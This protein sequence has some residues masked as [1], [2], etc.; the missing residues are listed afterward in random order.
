MI[1]C[2]FTNG[3]LVVLRQSKFVAAV[4]DNSANAELI[5]RNNPLKQ[6]F[7]VQ[8]IS[9]ELNGTF[10]FPLLQLSA[11]QSTGGCKNGMTSF[12]ELPC[13]FVGCTVPLSI[14]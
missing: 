1:I 8:E 4:R 10:A 13:H 9:I 7:C 5:H 2:S 6:K 3:L 14:T 11:T 12:F